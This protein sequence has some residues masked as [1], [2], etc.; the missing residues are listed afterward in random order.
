MIQVNNNLDKK[1]N[2]GNSNVVTNDRSKGK[3]GKNN[4]NKE[5]DRKSL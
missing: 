5:K 1:N 4:V 2:K 3:Q